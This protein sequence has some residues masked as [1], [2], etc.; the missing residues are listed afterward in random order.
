MRET[1]IKHT[2]VITEKE[3][4][5]APRESYSSLKEMTELGGRFYA[6][7]EPKKFDPSGFA[8]GNLVDEVITGDNFD[9]S[10]HYTIT[11]VK[12]DRRS[13]N[14]PMKL[15]N[16]L[17]E[18]HFDKAVN[19]G[20]L[21]VEWLVELA[22]QNKLWSTFSVPVVIKKITQ[23][24]FFEQLNLFRLEQLGKPLISEEEYQLG[25]MMSETLINHEYT[26]K[27]FGF[28]ELDR[29]YQTK[30]FF[31]LN[32]VDVKAMLDLLL[33]DHDKKIFYPIDLKTGIDKSFL[34]NFDQFKYNL[35]GSM[36]SA[37]IHSI[38]E[39]KEEFKDYKVAP[40][41]FI[42]ISREN[43]TVPGIYEM[44]EEYVVK[45][46]TGFKD[47]MG[48][49]KKGILEIIDDHKWYKKNGVTDGYR[50][51]IENN[52]VFTLKNPF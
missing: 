47:L 23:S 10:S 1:F 17:I 32:G 44:T 19:G 41:K 27:Y 5:D 3:Y 48:N 28:T 22:Q 40:F 26:N 51:I 15:L 36:Y 13:A 38:I 16:I 9:A 18:E 42:Y 8:L 21:D 14:N 31:K 34:R 50:D 11:D 2:E 30:I 33:I 12:S 4:R 6:E 7:R 37:S 25:M 49:H 52:G 45:G 24:N 46:M 39:T 43:P 35:Q 20:K 29:H